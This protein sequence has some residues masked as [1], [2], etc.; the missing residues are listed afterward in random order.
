[1]KHE[2]QLKL[3][4]KGNT[5]NNTTQLWCEVVY[6]NYNVER[7][8]SVPPVA[9]PDNK[10]TAP[11]AP[12]NVVPLLNISDPEDP[13]LLLTDCLAPEPRV[14]STTHTYTTWIASTHKMWF[15][16]K[17]CDTAASGE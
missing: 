16:L 2:R 1:M 11:D 17:G 8:Y 9:T 4:G 15:A 3:T 14:P 6:S 5:N 12:V 10:E 7:N 13:T